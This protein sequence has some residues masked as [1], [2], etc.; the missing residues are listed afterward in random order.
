MADG[1][2]GSAAFRPTSPQ[3]RLELLDA[4]RGFALCGILLANLV[5]FAGFYSLSFEETQS[6][7]N[8]DRAV[9]FLVDWLIE[10]KFYALFSVLFGIGFAL[11]AERARRVGAAFLPVWYRRMLVLTCIGLAHMLLV[12][13]GDILTL[14]SLLGLAL[15]LFATLPT[16]RLV[17]WIVALLL[18]PLVI[19]G[20]V[21]V[22]HEHAFWASA[23][24]LTGELKAML[25]YADRSSLEMLTSDSAGEVL[26]GNVL[27]ALQRPMA[28][29]RSGR[30]PQ[31][32]GQ[33]LLGVLLGRTMLRRVQR[34]KP[35]PVRAWL[36]CAAL[37][38]AASF[39]YAWIKGATGAAFSADAL[40]LVQ[41][42][43]YHAGSTLL[44]LG[45]AGAF[46]VAWRSDLL[47]R[48][49]GPLA[50]LGRMALT[51]Y[52]TQS[53]I[54]LLL[55]YG[56]GLSLMG[57]VPFALIPL[58]AGLILITQWALCRVWLRTASQGP[59]EHVWRRLAYRAS[60]ESTTAARYR[61]KAK[62]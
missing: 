44:V 18:A 16:R 48:T 15:P 51:N 9:L 12:W 31:V 59:L 14:Y 46:A 1:P 47:R 62:A 32:L 33:F 50:V 8:A 24:G 7:P 11:Q 58:I 5:S 34:D 29:L 4:T 25:G 38:L 49:L 35:L 20:L 40:G 6:L 28:Y 42:V 19:H 41:G 43:I 61:P 39:G 37:G 56:Y 3:E 55:F 36:A 2:G 30:I 60:T 54:G 13:H 17:H 23:A 52:I 10:G 27:G 21:M 53:V 22:S 57:H 45:Y 26:A